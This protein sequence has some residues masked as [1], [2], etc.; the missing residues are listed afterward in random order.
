MWGELWHFMEV[1]AAS[2]QQLSEIFIVI[3]LAY[4]CELT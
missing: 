1:A 3:G 2:I 4:V